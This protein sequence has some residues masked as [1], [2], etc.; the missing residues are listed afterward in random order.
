MPSDSWQSCVLH[1]LNTE[2]GSCDNVW[3][4]GRKQVHLLV[5]ILNGNQTNC[6]LF[7][8]VLFKLWNE[9]KQFQQRFGGSDRPSVTQCDSPQSNRRWK[10]GVYQ[11]GSDCRSGRYYDNSFNL[12]Y[13]CDSNNAR[14]V[15]TSCERWSVRIT[16]HCTRLDVERSFI[17]KQ[18]FYEWYHYGI[19]H[20]PHEIWYI[21][22]A[23]T[24]RN[25]GRDY[26]YKLMV[27]WIWWFDRYDT[28]VVYRTD[29]IRMH[30]GWLPTAEAILCEA[31]AYCAY[32]QWRVYRLDR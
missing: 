16:P 6:P 5:Y 32:S 27:R 19:W 23:S 12:S 10:C 15:T 25:F 21:L 1:K 31:F 9:V 4:L 22:L 28:C 7:D 11:S 29:G 8:I 24:V 26:Y 20:W 13:G 2:H 17:W 18:Q 14:R 3:S 30:F